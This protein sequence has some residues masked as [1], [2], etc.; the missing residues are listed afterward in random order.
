MTTRAAYPW[1]A[2]A[3]G[4][5]AALA[6]QLSSHVPQLETARLVLRAPRLEDF[7]DYAAILMSDRAR[8]MDGPFSRQSAWLDFTQYAAG[9]QLRGA[10]MWTAEQR[11]SG[12]V[13]GFFSAGME[14]GDREH[15]LGYLLTAGFEGQGLAAEAIAAVRDFALTALEL[16]SLVSYVDPDNLRSAK[17]AERSGAQRDTAAEAAFDSKVLVYRHLLQDG[18]GGM[19]AY[20]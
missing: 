8:Y 13:A 1:E 3:S 12:V 20:A 5:A 2:A 14:Y 9:W 17:A 15:E 16:P 19:E 6:Q 4:A 10:G 7:P 18:D 11:T